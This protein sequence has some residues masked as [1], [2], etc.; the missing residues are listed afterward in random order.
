MQKKSFLGLERSG[1]D[2]EQKSV[3]LFLLFSLVRAI[4]YAVFLYDKTLEWEVFR[5]CFLEGE[6]D[7]LLFAVG[8]CKRQGDRG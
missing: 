1:P 4:D 6:I 3:T 2:L 7:L 5:L 8:N